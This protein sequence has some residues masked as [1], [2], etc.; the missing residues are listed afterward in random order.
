[1]PSAALWFH[2][3]FLFNFENGGYILVSSSYT[4]ARRF[5]LKRSV[6][7]N[8]Q[9]GHRRGKKY[10]VG[11][12]LAITFSR[13]LSA[14]VARKRGTEIESYSRSGT[15]ARLIANLTG[16]IIGETSLNAHD[17]EAKGL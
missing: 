4:L 8:E 10:C 13:L 11:L 14:V 16:G 7:L 12:A 15:A 9:G 2:E 17:L 1:M 5:R 3:H 6:R